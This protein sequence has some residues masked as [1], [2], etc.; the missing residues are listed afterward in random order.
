M[1]IRLQ[2]QFGLRFLEGN[3]DRL[4][5]LLLE[6]LKVED[7]EEFVISETV[8]CQTHASVSIGV[9]GGADCIEV[10]ERHGALVIGY[11]G[12]AVWTYKLREPSEPL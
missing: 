11:L 5:P 3:K 1:R 2:M 7:L 6:K 12:L 8:P 4:D 9:E 10:G